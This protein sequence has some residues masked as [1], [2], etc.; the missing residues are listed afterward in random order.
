MKTYFCKFN[1][2]LKGALGI[3][4]S[5]TDTVMAENPNGARLALYEKYEQ[6][7]CFRCEERNARYTTHGTAHF[8]NIDKAIRYYGQQGAMER[9]DR[10]EIHLGRPLLKE[11]QH[12]S[13]IHEDGRY[14]IH[15]LEQPL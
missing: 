15:T 1:G 3:T 2:R 9:L 14:Q 6:I 10:G 4:Y 5:I 11:N 7:G 13:V 12:C 8:V